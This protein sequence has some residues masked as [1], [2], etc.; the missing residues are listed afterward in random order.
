MDVV[1]AQLTRLGGQLNLETR[2]GAGTAFALKFPVPHLLV[3]CLL[4][5][6]GG[7]TFAIP[8]EHV[9]TTA[10]LKQL[11]ASQLNDS[12]HCYDWE[13]WQDDTATPGL[14]L[15]TYWLPHSRTSSLA[16]TSICV[17]VR[18]QEGQSGIWLLADKLLEQ[19]ELLIKPLPS[20]LVSPNGLMGASL[21]PDGT[22]IPVLE[23]AAL[24]EQL[25]TKPLQPHIS[26][27]GKLNSPHGTP[28]PIAERTLTSPTTTAFPNNRSVQRLAPRILVVDDAALMRRRIEASL[29]ASGYTIDT[30]ADGLEAW[31][32]LQSHPSPD[33]IITD[34]EMPNMDGF[35]LIERCRRAEMNFPILVISSRLAEE[36]GREAQRLGA[37]GFLTKG[38]ST[39]E[40]LNKVAMYLSV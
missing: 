5:H 20:P 10:L 35:T 39:T 25:L 15:L 30:C 28:E 6:S 40:L 38:F 4:L 34:I 32:W 26:Q 22:L 7:Q 29:S 19:S 9:A 23:V 24:I 2:P 27:G 18:A 33:I 12:R 31:N 3:P 16:D 1:A 8:T 14:D 17:Y 37:T 13:I 11:E 36:W 21:Q